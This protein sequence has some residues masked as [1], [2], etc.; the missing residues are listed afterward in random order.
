MVDAL[1]ELRTRFIGWVEAHNEAKGYSPVPEELLGQLD[2]RIPQDLQRQ[3]GAAFRNGWLKTDDRKGCGCVVR[4]IERDGAGVGLNAITGKGA[5]KSG[6]WNKFY[7]QVADY[8]RLRFAAERRG[9]VVR[10]QDKLPTSL[11]GRARRCCCSS[12]TRSRPAT[13]SNR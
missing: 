4:S 5:G 2:R 8:S 3:I 13:R 10:L 1:N 9:L 12:K 7:V 11:C 6:P